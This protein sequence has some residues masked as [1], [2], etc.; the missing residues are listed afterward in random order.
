MTLD[1]TC[2]FAVPLTAERLCG[3]HAALFPTGRSTSYR[4]STRRVE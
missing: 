4:L 2:N 3:W 1:A